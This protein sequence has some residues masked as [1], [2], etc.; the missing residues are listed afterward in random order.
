MTNDKERII[1]DAVEYSKGRYTDPAN[2]KPQ[3]FSKVVISLVGVVAA[4]VAP[5]L[6]I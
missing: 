5:L 4:L 3:R 1:I 6:L 2:I